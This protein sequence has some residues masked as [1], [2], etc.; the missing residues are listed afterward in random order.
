MNEFQQI[1][2][3]L[4]SAKPDPRDYEPQLADPVDER[5]AIMK[6][7]GRTNTDIAS[8]IKISRVTVVSHLKKSEVERRVKTL[9]FETVH[10]HKE[11]MYQ[12]VSK[13]MRTLYEAMDHYEQNP[14]PAV[15]AAQA[16]LNGVSILK[17]QAEIRGQL[18]AMPDTLRKRF[19]EQELHA[20]TERDLKNGNGHKEVN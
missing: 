20:K 8:E 1:L 12:C 5:I 2:T 16:L 15:K 6:A 18:D 17:T 4:L 11:L 3:D 14:G 13:A 10:H 19:I 7:A 9:V